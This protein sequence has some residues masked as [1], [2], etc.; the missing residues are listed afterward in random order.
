MADINRTSD[1]KKHG[2]LAPGVTRVVLDEAIEPNGPITRN[3]AITTAGL[4]AGL[5]V[6]SVTNTASISIY[7]YAGS[8]VSQRKIKVLEWNSITKPIRELE[9]RE[10]TGL[11]NNIEVVVEHTGAVDLFLCITPQESLSNISATK[12]LIQD[13]HGHS[14][15]VNSDNELLI[16]DFRTH[17]KLDAI[18]EKLEEIVLQLRIITGT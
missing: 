4:R 13:E 5:Y 1:L 9:L 7:T 11:L 17:D 15:D 10:A 8:E 14:P 12:V 3:F 6:R 16:S 2:I 18:T